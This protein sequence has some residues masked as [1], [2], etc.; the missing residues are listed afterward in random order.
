MASVICAQ[1]FIDNIQFIANAWLLH[2]GFSISIKDCIPNKEAE[3]KNVITKCILEAK[4]LEETTTNKF[5]PV[6]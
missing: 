5:T 4:G 3:I 6:K 1:R 2:H